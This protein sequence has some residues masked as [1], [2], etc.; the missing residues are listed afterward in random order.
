LISKEYTTPSPSIKKNL[1][2]TAY[3]DVAILRGENL[4]GTKVYYEIIQTTLY[5]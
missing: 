4:L 1:L 2:L 3:P 5:W